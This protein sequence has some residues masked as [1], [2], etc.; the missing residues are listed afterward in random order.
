MRC[1]L[2]KPIQIQLPYKAGDVCGLEDGVVT[3]Q[4]IVQNAVV[5]QYRA[6]SPSP[7]YCISTQIEQIP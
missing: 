6:S 4:V 1:H 3:L 5:Q 2:P 7:D